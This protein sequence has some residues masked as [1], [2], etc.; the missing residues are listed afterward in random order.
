MARRSPVGA[1]IDVTSRTRSSA[2]RALRLSALL[3]FA[4]ALL[5]TA[6]TLSLSLL[7]AQT[8]EAQQPIPTP[9]PTTVTRISPATQS[10]T[11]GSEVVVDIMVDDVTSLAAYEF[12]LSF[13]ANVLSFTSVTKGPFLGSTGR[14]VTCLPPLLDV[15]KVRFACVTLN[16]SPSSVQ[17]C[18]STSEV[19]TPDQR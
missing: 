14:S 5:A 6:A 2:P 1:R 12:E 18:T 10:V 7:T 13:H 4:L 11:A 9:T 16:R 19:R 3:V 17:K 8:V 15:G